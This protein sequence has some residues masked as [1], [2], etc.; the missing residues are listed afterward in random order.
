MTK[1]TA[2]LCSHQG[3]CEAE[4]KACIAMGRV[5]R[6]KRCTP[7]ALRAELSEYGAWEKSELQDD[8]QN[9]IRIVWVAAGN[10]KDECGE[11]SKK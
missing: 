10:I 1:A 7:D 5:S 11:K 6:P 4:V 8:K 2:F 9:W 3:D